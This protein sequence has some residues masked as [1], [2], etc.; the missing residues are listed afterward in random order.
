MRFFVRVIACVGIALTAVGVA[1]CN[2]LQ[3]GPTRPITI[4]DDVARARAFADPDWESFYRMDLVTQAALRNQILTARMYI[5]DMEYHYYETRLTRDMQEEGFAATMASLALTTSATLIPVVQTK[6]L[7][8]GI[9]TGVIGADKAVTE[10]ILLSNTIRALQTQMRA[11]RK[12]EAGVIYAK[13][14]T[15]LNNN[16]KIITPIGDYTLAMALSDADAY[17]QAGTLNSALIGLSKTVANA[18]QVADQA[19]SDKGP[20]PG[21]VSSVRS[22]SLPQAN[23]PAPARTLRFANVAQDSTRVTLRAQ[24]FPNGSATADP[25]IVDYVKDILGPPSISI[26]GVLNAPGLVNLRQKISQCIDQR[27]AGQPCASGSL[28]QF[29]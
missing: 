17:Y 3:P 19:K 11:D 8:S 14:F 10:K 21:A 23:A 24:L 12:T 25:Q 2:T 1:G 18:D 15:N 27:K 9:A 22:A 26:F 29:R 28:K 5:A 7:L 20:N 13:M 4:D 6:T 16:T